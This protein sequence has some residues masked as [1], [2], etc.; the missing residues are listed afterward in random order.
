MSRWAE[1]NPPKET[2]VPLYRTSS[3]GWYRFFFPRIGLQCFG[4]YVLFSALQVVGFGLDL[5]GMIIGEAS[6]ECRFEYRWACKFPTP[7]PGFR[8]ALIK[9]CAIL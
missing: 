7:E 5:A 9:Q 4:G 6:T 2:F 8:N 1:T 3:I